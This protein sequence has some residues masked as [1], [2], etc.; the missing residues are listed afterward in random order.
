MSIDPE[1]MAGL[2]VNVATTYGV[3]I[4]PQMVD[5]DLDLETPL[6]NRIAGLRP[7][8]INVRPAAVFGKYTS[9]LY[10]YGETAGLTPSFIAG[11]DPHDIEVG[12]ELA[13]VVKKSYGAS[14]GIKDVD[15][16][17]STMPGAPISL[18]AE[19]MRDDAEL[20][21]RL[22]YMQTL[23]GINLDT[24][25]GNATSVVTA[26]DGLETL[27]TES[28]AGFVLD[29]N[30]SAFE[31]GMLDELVL[32][33]MAKGIYPTALYCNPIIHKAI[34]DAY[35]G[36][37]QVSIQMPDANAGVGA[38]LWV[39]RVVTPAGA[40]PIVS[41][42][43]FTIGGTAPTYTGDIFVMVERHRGVPLVYYEWAVL[44]TAI[45]LAKVMGRGRATSTEMAVWA[46][47]CLVER[48]SG[49]AHGLITGVAITAE[50]TWSNP[51]ISASS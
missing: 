49:S 30:G 9:L 34:S 20:L 14:A 42:R 51:T 31:P 1:I 35:Q 21:L 26:F 43:D 19:Q 18:N 17:A 48:T 2:T 47:L 4:D 24:A 41:D 38:G 7:N 6:F 45:P 28:N 46:H 33:M 15:I 23:R 11:G 5:V 40:L 39:T 8:F 44:P 16:L 50:G 25:R 32:Q 29:A 13:S 12:R 10:D 22:L 27:V 3:V 37:T 36:R